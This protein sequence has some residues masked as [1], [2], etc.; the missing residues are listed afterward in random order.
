V[1]EIE[2]WVRTRQIRGAEPA[3]GR[4]GGWIAER[5]EALRAAARDGSLLERTA[6]VAR[7]VCERPSYREAPRPARGELR[8]L[9]AGAE[10]ATA[11][12]Q[13]A[14]LGAPEPSPAELT[15]LLEGLSVRLWRG[16]AQGR[17][18]VVEPYRLRARRFR[19]VICASLQDGE[20]PRRETGGPFLSDEQRAA[21]GLPERIDPADEERYLF[22]VCLS[23][24]TEQ[25]C[26]SWRSSDD[27]G[28]AVARSP[29]L[30]DVRDL[31][32]PPPPAD[33]ES[34]D[35]LE[36][37]L[38]TVRGL[39]DV[40][41]PPTTAPTERELA[42][43]LAA[44]E[45]RRSEERPGPF[46]VEAA[47]EE[48]GATNLFGAST[49]EEY[50]RCS[51]RWLVQHE[52]DP[53]PLAPEPEA[54]ARGSVVHAVLEALYR[55]PPNGAPRPR[56]G[57]V[58]AWRER[59]LELLAEEAERKGIGPVDARRRAAYR[60]ME[61]SIVRMLERDAESE[62]AL[63]PDP[64][65]V[66][67]TFGWDEEGAKPALELGGFALHGRIDRIDVGESGVEGPRPGLIRDYK[68]GKNV[69]SAAKLSEEGKLQLQLYALAARELFEIDPVGAVYDPLG[70]SDADARPRGVLARDE[71]DGLLA[72]GPRFFSADFLD[73][74][75]IEAVLSEARDRARE[76]VGA[77]REGEVTRNPLGGE[78]PAY[79]TFQ[80]ICRRERAP[81][82]GEEIAEQAE[83]A[84]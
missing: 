20:F 3:I 65:L 36:R 64:A 40:V 53:Q 9:R 47:I 54:L 83:E 62:M 32:D 8:D 2:R 13:I 28:R 19:H 73:R 24:P 10:L 72:G 37:R 44:R 41:H 55:E 75:E 22:A 35:E 18:R 66:E 67:A 49:L 59:A 31:L 34:E 39:A 43:A 79:C 50:V 57:T 26:L 5:V 48:V 25:L 63:V 14:E 51:Y 6:R 69:P 56:P 60:A 45:P 38:T 15:R 84:Q 81:R 16:S 4:A 71:V 68:S 30:D 82:S 7:E 29:F 74:D 77:I 12:E 61:S 17:V 23:R 78:C 58:A 80:P 76:V 1:D 42:R 11:A 33:S 52:L 21:L 70:A 46:R 27:D